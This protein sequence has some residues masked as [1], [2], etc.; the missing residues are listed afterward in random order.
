MTAS[1]LVV[2]VD[3]DPGMRWAVD[4]LIRSLDYRTALFS[5]AEDFL[6][7]AIM[8]ECHCLI[9]DVNMGGMDGFEMVSKLTVDAA[10]ERLP[11]TIL[12]SAYTTPKMAETAKL[13]GAMVLLKKPFDAENLI[14]YVERAVSKRGGGELA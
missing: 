4:A 9:S 10:G 11:P 6:S 12:I 1:P 7:S 13:M 14:S 5:S 8:S 3:D 2:V